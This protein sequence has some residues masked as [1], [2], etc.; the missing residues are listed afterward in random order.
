MSE[1]LLDKELGAIGEAVRWTYFS[2][3]VCI[4]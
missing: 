1:L 4:Y 3:T 2:S